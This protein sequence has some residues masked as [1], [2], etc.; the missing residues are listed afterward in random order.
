MHFRLQHAKRRFFSEAAPDPHGFTFGDI[1]IILVGDYGQLEPIGD[2]SM[3]DLE[4]TLQS[5]PKNI[6][7]LWP[8]A[9]PGKL[10]IR[11]FE[12][13]VIL[14]KIHRSRDDMWW[15]ESCLRLRDFICTWDDDY[16][17]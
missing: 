11:T 10:L 8:H 4:A 14:K 7:H 13:A 16:V 12:D 5:C 3:C 9:F 6:R 2:W 1:A 15:T 17:W